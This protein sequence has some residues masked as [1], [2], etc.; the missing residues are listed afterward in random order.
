MK[1]ALFPVAV[2]LLLLPMAD[3]PAHATPIAEQTFNMAGTLAGGAF[4]STSTFIGSFTVGAPATS[5]TWHL[6]AFSAAR[7][8]CKTGCTPKWDFSKLQI[9]SGTLDLVGTL[10][11]TWAGNYFALTFADHT[12]K[13]TW[14]RD[15]SFG[16]SFAFRSL[17]TGTYALTPVLA[18]GPAPVPEPSTFLLLGSA[19]GGFA[20]WRR[21]VKR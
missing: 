18:P 6:S 9:D 11:G 3:E 16:S 15:N 12:R 14:E 2:W 1:I 4:G 13:F 5:S 19:L 17:R 10:G 21:A 8:A 20:V 7:L